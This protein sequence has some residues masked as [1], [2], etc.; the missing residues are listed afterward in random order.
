[1]FCQEFI[2]VK[3]TQSNLEPQR[4][5]GKKQT[6]PPYKHKKSIALAITI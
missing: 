4:Y 1:M 2:S 6:H 3:N 5:P